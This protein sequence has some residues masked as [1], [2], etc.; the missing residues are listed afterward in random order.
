MVALEE[1]KDEKDLVAE[2]EGIKILYAGYIKR[3]YKNITIDYG[4]RWFNKGFR[5]INAR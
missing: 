4:K 3:Y 2:F 1:Q 5:L